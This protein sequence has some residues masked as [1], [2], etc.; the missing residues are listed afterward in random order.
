[1]CKPPREVTTRRQDRPTEKV[2]LCDK[3]YELCMAVRHSVYG[4]VIHQHERHGTERNSNQRFPEGLPRLSPNRV[5]K[6][7]IHPEL[8]T[9]PIII[10]QS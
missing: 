6:L 7:R 3:S 1:M 8:G 2:H 4:L 5:K 9:T 10:P